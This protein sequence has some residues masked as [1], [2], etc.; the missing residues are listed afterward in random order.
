MKE[1]VHP[2]IKWFAMFIK[3][4]IFKRKLVHLRTHECVEYRY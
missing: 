3:R 4:E 1:K 2:P